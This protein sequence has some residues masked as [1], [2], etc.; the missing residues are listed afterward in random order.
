[1]IGGEGEAGRYL[2]GLV[3]PTVGSVNET[4]DLW[5]PYRLVDATGAMV[6][7]VS[8]FLRD[9]QAAGDRRRRSGRMRWT[10]CAGFGSGGRWRCR[11][12]RRPG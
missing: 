12:G 6:Q 3:V 5:E 8:A 2:A 10:C 1:M 9:L 4:E 11:G 7:A